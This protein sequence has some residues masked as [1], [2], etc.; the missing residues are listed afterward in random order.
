MDKQRLGGV[1]VLGSH[2]PARLIGADG[3]GRNVKG[4]Q[5]LANLL[6]H[7]A[8]ASVAWATVW[9]C[10]VRGVQVGQG[11]WRMERMLALNQCQSQGNPLQHAAGVI[12]RYHFLIHAMGPSHPK[13]NAAPFVVPACHP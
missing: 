4:A 3:D 7:A 12:P 11:A 5:P 8:V 2:E 1:N 10:E 6:E 9:R 13:S